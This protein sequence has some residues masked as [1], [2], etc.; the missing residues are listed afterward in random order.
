MRV[1]VLCSRRFLRTRH[2]AFVLIEIVD[3][4]LIFVFDGFSLQFQ[5]IGDESSVWRPIVSHH[6]N[7]LRSFEPF[8]RS[9]LTRVLHFFSDL[10][11]ELI[12]VH[13]LQPIALTKVFLRESLDEQETT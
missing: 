1:A 13:V 11:I 2:S 6:L 8:D 9:L 4:I 10:S 12:G 7:A 3:Q 5:S